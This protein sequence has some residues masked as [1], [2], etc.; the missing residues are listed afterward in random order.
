VFRPFFAADGFGA[1]ADRGRAYYHVSRRARQRPA[2]R[3]ERDGGLDAYVGSESWV[4][5]VNE[6]GKPV[7]P[8]LKA[9]SLDLL[10]TNRHL[11]V[12]A[13]V[14]VGGSQRLTCELDEGWREIRVVSGP[15]AP[16]SGLPE[17]R[18]L[19]DVISHLSLNHL[20][21]IDGEN[22]S[23]EG[24]AG[25]AA[26]A[27]RQL[28]R[29]YAPERDVEAHALI[30][31]LVDVSARPAVRR[32]PPLYHRRGDMAA[33]MA[34]ARGLEVALTFEDGARG[35]PVIAALL[36]RVLA[37]HADANSFVET[38]LRRADKRERARFAPRSGT[39]TVL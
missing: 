15:S 37:G 20:S 3:D 36:D 28:L 10:C 1:R 23:G 16:R 38:V 34:F 30:D 39:R 35:A 26:G 8:G 31:G 22:A 13:M 4:S 18:R 2:L 7:E 33:P 11:P 17:G 19:W 14:E 29:I 6:A 25:R 21:L 12:F 9:L 24:Q 27:L 32:I 5:I